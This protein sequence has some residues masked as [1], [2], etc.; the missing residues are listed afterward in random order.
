MSRRIKVKATLISAPRGRPPVKLS[1]TVAIPDLRQPISELDAA[2]AAID[3]L[4]SP[5][6]AA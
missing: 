4:T 1:P 5:G 2:M 6:A 3:E